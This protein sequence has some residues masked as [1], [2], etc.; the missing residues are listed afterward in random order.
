M[1]VAYET[2][3]ALKKWFRQIFILALIPLESVDDY[4][5]NTI[6]PAMSQLT[7]KYK[8]LQGFTEYVINNYFEGSFPQKYWNHFL[9]IGNRTNNHVEGYNLKLKKFIGA[10]SPNIF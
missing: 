5:I 2:D 1:K 7:Y 6:M 4:W 10:K 8:K 3:E 9:T